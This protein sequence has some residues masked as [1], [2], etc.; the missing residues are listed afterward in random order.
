MPALSPKSLASEWKKGTFRPAYYFFGEDSGSKH[1][2]I[3]ALRK[4]VNAD[5]FNSND[6]PGD[7]DEHIQEIISTCSTPPMFS[8]RRLVVVRNAKFSASGRKRLAEYLRSPLDST[9]LV[10][11]SE[12]RKPT[13]KDAL[14]AGV[15]A[16]GGVVLFKPLSEGEAATRLKDEAKR[17]GITLDSDAAQLLVD[18]AGCEWGILRAELAKVLLFAKDKG[19]ANAEDVMSCLG[20]KHQTNPFD[21]PRSLERRD[22]QKSLSLLKNLLHEGNNPFG[23]LFRVTQTLQK[24]LKAKRLSKSGATQDQIF[25]ELRLQPY[26]DRDYMKVLAKIG[27]PG[28]VRN[29]RDCL[30]TEIT[31][32]TQSW[33]DPS[34]ELEQLVLKVCRKA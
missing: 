9:T 19:K 33:L 27:E 4:M 15:E 20:Y 22:L 16:L 28:L 25:R 1:S 31:L 23:L 2:A 3:Q 14:A 8:P 11:V 17:A 5:E 10:L 30:D 34:I 7:T 21:L 13:A 18:E 32:K 24:Q 26:Y 29:L 12:E 6:F